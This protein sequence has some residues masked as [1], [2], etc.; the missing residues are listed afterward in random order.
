[1]HEFIKLCTKK[2]LCLSAGVFCAV[3][4]HPADT[5]VSKL[6]QDAGSNF[7]DAAKSLGLKGMS[8]MVSFFLLRKKVTL[9]IIL[10]VL[11]HGSFLRSQGQFLQNTKLLTFILMSYLEA[12]ISWLSL[13]H[14]IIK[15]DEN[16][17]SP[18]QFLK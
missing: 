12:F 8:T 15:Y 9:I 11:L 18:W 6:N 16:I 17:S 7:M 3:V 1:M 5:I 4:S 10:N 2:T 13:T 14:I